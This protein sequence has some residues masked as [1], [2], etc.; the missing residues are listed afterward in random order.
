MH[1]HDECDERIITAQRTGHYGFAEYLAAR[2]D[3][4]H[5]YQPTPALVRET[6]PAVAGEARTSE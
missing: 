1:D 2:C 5:G 4:A 6:E 3:K